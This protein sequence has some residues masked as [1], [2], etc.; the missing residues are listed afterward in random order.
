MRRTPVAS[1]SLPA[2]T[3]S[4]VFRSPT[5]GDPVATQVELKPGESHAVH[6]DFRAAVPTVVVR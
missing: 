4:V 6:A 2:G 3:Y 1:L 5:F